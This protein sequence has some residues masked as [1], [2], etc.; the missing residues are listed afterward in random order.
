MNHKA[1][2]LMSVGLDSTKGQNENLGPTQIQKENGGKYPQI[3]S[4]ES[5]M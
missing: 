5:I 4:N 3:N 2:A 1:P